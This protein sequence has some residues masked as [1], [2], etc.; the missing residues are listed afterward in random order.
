M[1]GEAKTRLIPALGAEKAAMLHAALAGRTLE[2]ASRCGAAVELC[3]APDES[4]P[5]FQECA[6]DFDVALVAQGDGDLG[7]RMLRALDAALGEFPFV[8][9]VGCDCPALS[10]RELKAAFASL[11]ADRPD[12]VPGATDVVLIPAEDGGYVL[13]GA[14]R[15]DPRMFDGIDWGTGEVMAQQRAALA[16]CGLAHAELPGLWDVDRPA[17]LE[18][19]GSLKPP[20]EFFLG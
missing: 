5:F 3:C 16:A 12:G 18:R 6:E 13:V 9:I 2:P 4:H 14:R 11:Q 20:L 19:L 10:P 7:R 8:L 1:P 17:D 15:T